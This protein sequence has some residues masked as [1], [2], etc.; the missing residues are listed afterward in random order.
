MKKILAF[1]LS[2]L[3]VM[4]VFFLGG[5]FFP[6]KSPPRNSRQTA[7]LS[8][9]QGTVNVKRGDNSA[10]ETVSTDQVLSV[11]DSIATA[12]T[13]SATL[14]FFDGSQTQLYP[15]T[16]ITL[17]ELRASEDGSNKIILF[18]QLWGKTFNRVKRLLD[19]ASRY[20]I[21]TPTSVTAVRGT[22]FVVEVSNADGATQVEVEEGVVDVIAQ[23]ITVPVHPGESILVEPGKSP[24]LNNEETSPE[25]EEKESSV[26]PTPEKNTNDSTEKESNN[27]EEGGENKSESDTSSEN[28]KTDCDGYNCDKQDDFDDEDDQSCEE[29]MSGGMDG[30]CF[31]KNDNKDN[32]LYNQEG[33]CSSNNSGKCWWNEIRDVENNSA[34]ERKLVTCL[35]F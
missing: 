33:N 9:I 5:N 30:S 22:E 7:T 4:L 21:K 23:K 27:S 18:E 24:R 29:G 35:I 1:P 31:D 32:E 28:D 6:Q 8:D 12:E 15:N 19:S 34:I 14:I 20:E 2:A 16:L 11:G 10:W 3:A 26:T 13:A 25:T 17:T